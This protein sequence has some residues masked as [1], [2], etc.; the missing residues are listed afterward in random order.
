MT[1]EK[2]NLKAKAMPGRRIS[3]RDFLIFPAYLTIGL[4]I[5][6]ILKLSGRGRLFL[7]PPGAISEASFRALCLSCGKCEEICPQ[8]VIRPVMLKEDPGSAGTPQLDF[9]SNYCNLCMKCI[10]ICP[11]GALLPVRQ[12]DVRIGV[13]KVISE[14]CSPWL[15][16]SCGHGCIN[17]CPFGAITAD[18]QNRPKIK[19][20]LCVGC[21]I[22]EVLCSL[23]TNEVFTKGIVVFPVDP[24]G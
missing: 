21:G 18:G 3:R 4:G 11:T 9:S 20:E 13:A 24:T 19:P 14:R 22:C 6:A 8:L 16:R 5:G 2:E 15:G 10:E 7:R 23:S 1:L 12:K 17:T